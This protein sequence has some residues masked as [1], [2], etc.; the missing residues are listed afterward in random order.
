LHLLKM[1][2]WRLM[3]QPAEF[4]H[5]ASAAIRSVLLFA[6]LR[7]RAARSPR[8]S[9]VTIA[10][11]EHMGDIVAAE[12]VARAARARFPSAQIRW[13]VRPGYRALPD[14]YDAVDETILVRCLTEWL[15]AWSF[16]LPG[17]IWDLHISG[18]ACPHCQVAFDKLG[19]AGAVTFESYYRLGNLLTAQCLS[20]GLAPIADASRLRPDGASSTAVDRLDLPPNFIVMHC[21]SNETGRDWQ[22]ASWAAL[23]QRL[24]LE[25]GVFV[26]EV[27]LT[28]QAVTEDGPHCRGLCGQLSLLES[29]EVIRRARLFVGIDSGPAHLANAVR[30]P[31]VLML[32]PYAAFDRYMPY[33]GF[34]QNEAGARLIWGEPAVASIDV[35]TVL[36]AVLDRLRERPVGQQREVD[37]SS[38]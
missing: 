28:P 36:H 34:Y 1:M 4:P 24:M 30:T 22:T 31:G 2:Y 5:L 17:A 27:G 12:P 23:T 7:L 6:R 21:K 14:R 38:C 3:R 29:A 18:R 9:T 32:G 26:V 10:L 19:A 33:S 15:L 25:H 16:G 13:I 35:D 20:A 11:T 8:Q 37:R